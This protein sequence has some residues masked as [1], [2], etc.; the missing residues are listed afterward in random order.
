MKLSRLVTLL[1]SALAAV[2]VMT[3]LVT[4]P[5]VPDHGPPPPC[6][7]RWDGD[8][9]GGWVP[10]TP[11]LAGVEDLL[12][13]G[14]P[15]EVLFCAYPGENYETHRPL[16]GSRRVSGADRLARDLSFLPATPA[17]MGF[18][19]CSVWRSAIRRVPRPG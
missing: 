9:F 1:L 6:P 10:E 14:S 12:V 15:A 18:P 16:G 17:V 19:A 5:A 3:L 2:A 11:R 13:P 7:S 8:R 4:T